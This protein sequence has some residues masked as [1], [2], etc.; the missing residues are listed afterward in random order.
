LVSLIWPDA[1]VFFAEDPCSTKAVTSC[2]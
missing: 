1:T 2:S